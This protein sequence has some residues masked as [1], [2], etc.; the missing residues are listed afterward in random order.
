VKKNYFSSHKLPKQQ[1]T[2]FWSQGILG[3]KRQLTNPYNIVQN[4]VCERRNRTL[5]E[6]ARSMLNAS[7]LRNY[8]WAESIYTAYY[9]QNCSFTSTLTNA[10]PYELWTSLKSNLNHLCIFGCQACSHI[11]DQK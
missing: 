11:L 3:V 9:L 10:T 7:Q 8:F 6:S 4:D 2:S 1:R 5:I